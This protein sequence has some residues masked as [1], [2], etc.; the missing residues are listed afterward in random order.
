MAAAVRRQ[1]AVRRPRKTAAKPPPNGRGGHA[2]AGVST[3]N[4]N[5]INS[6]ARTQRLKH[7]GTAT[8]T[9]SFSARSGA[10]AASMA[11][12]TAAL[13]ISDL[14]LDMAL[15]TIENG[16]HLTTL[17]NRIATQVQYCCT[18]RHRLPT[19]TQRQHRPLHGFHV[20]DDLQQEHLHGQGRHRRRGLH[21][22]VVAAGPCVRA[23][24]RHRTAVG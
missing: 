15:T 14:G 21:R 19:E 18:Q 20:L 13:S 7:N 8:H 3:S 12:K 24:E 5:H 1:A 4:A 16:F 2:A 9:C 22:R 17:E 23:V 11:A 6:L 10:T